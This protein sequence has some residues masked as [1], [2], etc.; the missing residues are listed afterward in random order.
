[1]NY[2]SYI[3]NYCKNNNCIFRKKTKNTI[4]NSE[5]DSELS[6]S[7]DY[8]PVDIRYVILESEKDRYV[9]K[10]SVISFESL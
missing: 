8:E 1:M 9:D 2:F 4:I 3:L 10:N 5:S 6:E 7:D